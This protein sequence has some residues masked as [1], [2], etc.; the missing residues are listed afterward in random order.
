MAFLRSVPRVRPAV[1]AL[2]FCAA[3]GG[4]AVLLL[5]RASTCP[6]EC[7]ERL[8]SASSPA[9]YGPEWAEPAAFGVLV[10]GLVGTVGAF[11]VRRRTDSG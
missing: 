11:V 8:V 7:P 1:A 10:V 3:L 5:Q 6:V 9:T 2:I 4:A